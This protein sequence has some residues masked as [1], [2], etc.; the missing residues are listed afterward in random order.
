MRA[1]RP[2]SAADVTE[3]LRAGF[4]DFARAPAFG[5]FFGA[6]FSAI[7]IVIFLQLVVWGASFEVL[8]FAIGFPLIGPF[9][10]VG[11]YEVS[12]RLEAGEPLDWAA[13]L[14]VVVRQRSR[15]M[16]MMMFVCVF[17]F[18]VWVYLAHLIFALSFGLA[19]MINVMSSPEILFTAEGVTMLVAGTVVGG[20]LAFL[21]FA[22]T[23]TSLPLLLEREID[24]VSAMIVSFRSVMANL[25]PMLLWAAIVAGATMV[26]MVP[27]FLGIIVVFPV[28]GHAS[29]WLYRKTIAPL[30]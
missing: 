2:L 18:L 24:V 22:L 28:L 10:A 17:F 7:G 27:I 15:Q 20:A 21:L 12:R 1:I 26:A 23:V 25:R 13:V 4:R 14:T 29:W 30:A 3:S 19:P 9:A 8:P 16:P 11:L 6:V 5:V